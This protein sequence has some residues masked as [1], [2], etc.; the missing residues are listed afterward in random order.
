MVDTPIKTA[1]MILYW[2][3]MNHGPKNNMYNQQQSGAGKKH[4]T[5]QTIPITFDVSFD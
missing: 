3:A 2:P 4:N 1:N 5:V